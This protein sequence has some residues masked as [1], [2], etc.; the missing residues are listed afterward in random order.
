MRQIRGTPFQSR[1]GGAFLHGSTARRDPARTVDDFSGV[2]RRFDPRA[3]RLSLPPVGTRT[4][5]DRR[6]SG[7]RDRDRQTESRTDRARPSIAD[8]EQA[9]RTLARRPARRRRFRRRSAACPSNGG[10]KT[11]PSDSSGHSARTSARRAC[12]IRKAICWV[13]SPIPATRRPIRWCG[14]TAPPATSTTTATVP[15]SSACCA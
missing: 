1:A 14:S 8:I 9:D 7:T 6:G 13:T 12:R 5:R 10:R 2:A 11:P 3:R 15:T 4:R